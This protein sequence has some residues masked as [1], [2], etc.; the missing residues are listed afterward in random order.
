VDWA[1]FRK[2]KIERKEQSSNLS[3]DNYNIYK[4]TKR[5]KLEFKKLG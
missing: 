5:K 2:T 4:K 3:L 1:E